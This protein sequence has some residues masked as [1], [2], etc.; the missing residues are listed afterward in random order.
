MN[1]AFFHN[2]AVQILR[3]TLGIIFIWMGILKLFN[4]SPIQDALT[5]AIPGLGESQVLLFSAAFFEVLVGGALL[6]NKFVKVAAVVLIIHL[7]VITVAMLF[8]QGFAPRFPVLSLVGEHALKNVVLIAAA[9]VLVSE[10]EENQHHT[11]SHNNKEQ[12]HAA[13]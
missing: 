12:E 7:L 10:K 6:A 2:H 11:V 13:D 3:I 4:V 5:T 8:S 1:L 9:L